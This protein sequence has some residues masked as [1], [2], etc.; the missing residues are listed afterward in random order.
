MFTRFSRSISVRDSHVDDSV[1]L[2]FPP[3][4]MAVT[5]TD[6]SCMTVSATSPVTVVA[7]TELPDA[8]AKST[9]VTDKIYRDNSLM[10]GIALIMRQIYEKLPYG[11]TSPCPANIIK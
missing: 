8:P 11:A 2:T 1:S 5:D 7:D 6:G 4:L 3:P 9:D 10:V